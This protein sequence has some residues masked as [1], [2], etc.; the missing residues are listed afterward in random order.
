MVDRHLEALD[1]GNAEGRTQWRRR[2]KRGLTCGAHMSVIGKREGGAAQRR[3]LMRKTYSE[4]CA[5][6][7]RDCRT[8]WVRRQP[9]R[10]SGLAQ[11]S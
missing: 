11:V 7:V 3:K 8:G 5:K 4:G 2:S 10:G 1:R 6:G 9:R